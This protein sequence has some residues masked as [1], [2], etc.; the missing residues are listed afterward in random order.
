[1]TTYPVH[2]RRCGRIRTNGTQCGSPALKDKEVCYYHDQNRP[3]LIQ[4][5]E[6][7]K[8]QSKCDMIV[9]VFEDAHSMQMT[10]RHLVELLLSH[11]IDRQDARLVLSALQIASSNLK[12]MQKEKAKPN[13]IVVDAAKAVETPLGMTPWSV[14]GDGHDVEEEEPEGPVKQAVRQVNERWKKLY[15]GHQKW[16][17]D[18]FTF[19]DK[20]YAMSEPTP[21]DLRTML[22]SMRDK[23][24]RGAKKMGEEMEN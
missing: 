22:D 7:G 1:M 8:H 3:A 11:R 4:Y 12:A 18:S 2:I 15:Q 19:I 13:Q 10:L 24:E 9:P 14:S 17:V 23:L 16:M 5:F 20:T 6:D 21:R